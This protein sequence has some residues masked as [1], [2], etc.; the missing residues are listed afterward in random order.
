MSA[1]V[2]RMCKMCCPDPAMDRAPTY[3]AVRC[4]HVACAMACA[5]FI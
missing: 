1:L 3:C 5:P 2:S 4:D